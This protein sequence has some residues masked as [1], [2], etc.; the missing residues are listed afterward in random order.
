MFRCACNL[1][2]LAVATAPWVLTRNLACTFVFLR[3]KVTCTCMQPHRTFR[4]PCCPNNLN[5]SSH[6]AW[7]APA[8]MLCAASLT[9]NACH[10]PSSV[11]PMSTLGSS[12]CLK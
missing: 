1:F 9:T 4:Q 2:A 6:A 3:E 7:L 10:S 8:G 11:V 12:V 5:Q